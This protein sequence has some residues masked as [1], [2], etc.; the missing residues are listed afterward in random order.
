MFFFF[1]FFIPRCQYLHSIYH[2]SFL[3]IALRV[4]PEN[5]FTPKKKNQESRKRIWDVKDLSAFGRRY[6]HFTSSVVSVISTVLDLCFFGCLLYIF[7]ATRPPTYTTL[8]FLFCF[9]SPARFLY[10]L[11]ISVYPFKPDLLAN[12]CSFF[13]SKSVLILEL[14]RTLAKLVFCVTEHAQMLISKYKGG[15]QTFALNCICTY[16]SVYVYFILFSLRTNCTLYDLETRTQ[17]VPS[18]P[19]DVT[20]FNM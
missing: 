16:T 5:I 12:L 3:V 19:S 20:H 2:F 15:L 14:A 11:G 17:N 7:E 13:L 8:F 1:S 18:V 4:T 10:N 9:S 6:F